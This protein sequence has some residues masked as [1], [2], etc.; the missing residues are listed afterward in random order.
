MFSLER[1]QRHDP[2]RLLFFRDIVW[3]AFQSQSV[4]P[5]RVLER[6]DAAVAD[7]ARQRHG[8]VEILGRLA[9][10]ANDDVGRDCDIGNGP[11]KLINDEEV[12]LSCVATTHRGKDA[13]GTSLQR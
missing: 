12:F 7:L 4:G 3:H 6:E 11:P 10:E 9:W 13:V 8:E 5:W 2:P 1:L